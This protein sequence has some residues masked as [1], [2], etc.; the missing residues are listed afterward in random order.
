MKA[1]TIL[2]IGVIACVATAA[3]RVGARRH[4]HSPEGYDPCYD[5]VVDNLDPK[6]DGFLAVKAGPAV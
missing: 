6:G 5:G 3:A 1:A 4:Q 2:T